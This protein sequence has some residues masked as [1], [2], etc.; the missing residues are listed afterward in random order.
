MGD[1]IKIKIRSKMKKGSQKS[2][3]GPGAEKSAK[4]P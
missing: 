3:M 2:E 1:E 4:H